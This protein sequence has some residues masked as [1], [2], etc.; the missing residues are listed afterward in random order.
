MFKWSAFKADPPMSK[1]LPKHLPV[2]QFVATWAGSIWTL[3]GCLGT[4]GRGGALAEYY[5]VGL[6]KVQMH[7]FRH[8][9]AEPGI[10]LPPESVLPCA[11]CLLKSTTPS[12][13]PCRT[14][15]RAATTRR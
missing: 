10:S 13:T 2:Y 4:V 8:N 15:A 12:K 6:G 14:S 7:H 3:Q 5:F 9:L 1:H 11:P